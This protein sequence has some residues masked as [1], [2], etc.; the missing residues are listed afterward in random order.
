MVTPRY[1]VDEIGDVVQAVSDAMTGFTVTYMYGNGLEI[2]DNC[3]RMAQ[4][5][6]SAET[7]FPLVA[8]IQDFK[9]T[10]NDRGQRECDL[11]LIIANITD[12][13]YRADERYQH[14]FKPYLYP[15]YTELLNQLSKSGAFVIADANRIPHDKYDRV[16]CGAQEVY[17]EVNPFSDA[18]DAI[19]IENLS[20]TLTNKINCYE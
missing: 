18:I 20:L 13:R 8:L 7:R 14:S 19:E 11:N 2:V 1:I 17:G 4:V 6:A 10:V 5:A 16:F 9:E 12:K 3:K 15:I